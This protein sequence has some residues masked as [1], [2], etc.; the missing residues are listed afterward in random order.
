MKHIGIITFHRACNYG[1]VLQALSL[2]NTIND[3]EDASAHLIDHRCEAIE[4]NYNI[5][6][7]FQSGS[8]V[9]TILL[10]LLRINAILKRNRL[11]SRFL[12]D[13]FDLVP[14]D[15]INTKEYHRFVTGSDQIWN[16]K[17]TGNDKNY[18]L[19]FV[20]DSR[21]KVSYAASVG[22]V[23]NANTHV[24]GELVSDFHAVAVR[25]QALYDALKEESCPNLTKTIDPVFLTSK[26][27]WLETA[28]NTR[29]V[30]S[31]YILV[32]IMGVTKQGDYLVELG[33]KLAKKNNCKVILIGDQERWYKYRDVEHFGV[34][35]PTEF[36]NL[37]ANAKTVLT[38][39]FHATSFSILFNTNFLV[40]CH[41]NSPERIY[42]LLDMT[43]L[44]SHCIY[45]GKISSEP[46]VKIDWRDVE[47]K[48]QPE[49]NRSK[50]FI[51]K[52]I[53]DD[54]NS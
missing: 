27:K 14:L 28:G 30:D 48:L 3:R 33:K 22:K 43:G 13:N 45:D 32:F 42:S 38:N 44:R 26:E 5:K 1:A 9:K 12:S 4:K 15:K 24:I 21:Q 47:E 31:D 40:E 52:F 17:L 39:S 8:G 25:E 10:K 20:K 34:A 19:D 51:E 18:Y 37:I 53:I 54:E 11:F 29:C 49:I 50:K 23:E 6:G 2:Y 46:P 7:I 35:S 41:I 16:L 36:L